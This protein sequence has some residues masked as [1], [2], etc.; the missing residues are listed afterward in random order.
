LVPDYPVGGIWNHEGRSNLSY[1]V[2]SAA[3]GGQYATIVS[4]MHNAAAAWENVA[5]VR[6][7][8]LDVFDDDCTTEN[9]DVV[10]DVGV[11]SP[12]SEAA[13]ARAFLPTTSRTNRRLLL[14]DGGTGYGTWSAR[15]LV[16]ILVHE[17]GHV[18]GLRHEFPRSV[19][20]GEDGRCT[21]VELLR[22]SV[23]Q[24][25]WCG[26]GAT[27]SSSFRVSMAPPRRW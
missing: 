1:C 2:A 16:R 18:L 15:E 23:M 3:F 4:A 11:S 20:V 10:F 5:N 13:S 21:E 7:V 8:H 24:Y 14:N 17:L 26:D 27:T 12:L 6:F 25:D 9:D 22:A 19:E